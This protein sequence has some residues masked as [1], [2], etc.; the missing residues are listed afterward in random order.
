MR[1]GGLLAE[2]A[3]GAKRGDGPLQA[4]GEH[5]VAVADEGPH[6]SSRVLGE[7]QIA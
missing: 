7:L 5:R 1:T 4:C 6:R 2:L 3:L